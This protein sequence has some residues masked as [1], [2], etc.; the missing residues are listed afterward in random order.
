MAR[1]KSKYKFKKIVFKLS[2]KEYKY[3]QTCLV[4]E[5]TTTNKLIKKFIRQGFD[6]IRPR[7]TEWENQKQPKNQLLL[8]ETKKQN[9]QIS[10]L[11]EEGFIYNT[12]D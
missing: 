12:K 10:L 1:K 7:V 4:L 11:E 2:S 5:K 3:L 8:F 6:D 9:L